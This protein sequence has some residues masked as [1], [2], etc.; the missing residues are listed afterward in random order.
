M[1]SAATIQLFRKQQANFATFLCATSRTTPL[2]ATASGSPMRHKNRVPLDKMIRRRQ[3]SLHQERSQRHFPD[4]PSDEHQKIMFE[5]IRCYSINDDQVHFSPG[6]HT[7][8]AHEDELVLAADGPKQPLCDMPVSLL[9]APDVATARFASIDTESI[10]VSTPVNASG[11]P[12]ASSFSSVTSTSDSIVIDRCPNSDWEDNYQ[13]EIS[14]FDQEKHV[15]SLPPPQQEATETSHTSE[16]QFAVSSVIR[17]AVPNQAARSSERDTPIED[18]KKPQFA[19]AEA[20]PEQ[21]VTIPVTQFEIFVHHAHRDSLPFCHLFT[22]QPQS[23]TDRSYDS[24]TFFAIYTGKHSRKSPGRLVNRKTSKHHR[25]TFRQIPRMS[26]IGRKTQLWDIPRGHLPLVHIRLP[27][28]HRRPAELRQHRRHT[29]IQE[30]STER[31]FSSASQPASLPHNTNPDAAKLDAPR[32]KSPLTNAVR[33]WS[34]YATRAMTTPF[35]ESCQ[36]FLPECLAIFTAT[37]PPD[38]QT[39]SC[40]KKA[41]ERSFACELDRSNVTSLS[42]K[43]VLVVIMSHAAAVQPPGKVHL[44]Q[45]KKFLETSTSTRP[46]HQQVDPSPAQLPPIAPSAT[47]MRTS[48]NIVASPSQNGPKSR[49]VP[50][51]SS[52]QPTPSPLVTGTAVN[53]DDIPCG[54]RKTRRKP[55]PPSIVQRQQRASRQHTIHPRSPVAVERAINFAIRDT[56]KTRETATSPQKDHTLGL[57]RPDLHFDQR[58]GS[59]SI[60]NKRGEV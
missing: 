46:S 35:P 57:G 28:H 16:L 29:I 43:K 37:A 5:N 47:P 8:V 18:P 33:R 48:S 13:I 9:A 12:P 24:S 14:V 19:P 21:M 41:R 17:E 4:A 27:G 7:D 1:K 56:I 40:R 51:S 2:Q 36:Q 60:R 44:D 38:S 50:S 39:S 59:G 52:R 55:T 31:Q 26:S 22:K 53:H 30:S 23:T 25:Q 49:A 54:P 32:R 58:Q 15:P 20:D 6:R 3:C 42:S 11:Q 10:P 45:I 34:V